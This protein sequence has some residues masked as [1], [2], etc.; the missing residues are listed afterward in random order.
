MS[1][2]GERTG[3]ASLAPTSR[4]LMVILGT[5]P[6]ALD[7]DAVQGLLTRD[8]A[9]G[10]DPVTVQGVTYDAVDLGGRLG[11]AIDAH[12]PETRIVLLTHGGR[13]G[14]IQV[15]RVRG[16]IEIEQSQVLPLPQQF[17][18]EERNWYRGM[19][20]FE[21][22]IALALNT[23]WVLQGAGLGHGRF[24]LEWQGSVPRLLGAQPGQTVG[25]VSKC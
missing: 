2:R 1:L 24:S 22:D 21:D 7:A 19:I 23:E 4:F 12:S 16:L 17:H 25:K 14:R 9:G 5:R 6:F 11:L 3:A 15:D 20:L 10:T 18:S 8:A 13:Q